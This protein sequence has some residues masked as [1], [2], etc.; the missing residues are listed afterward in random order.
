MIEV[1][2]GYPGANNALVLSAITT[3]GPLQSMG[4]TTI[5]R[6]ACACL[7]RFVA[8][9]LVIVPL[10]A[11]L[12][13]KLKSFPSSSATIHTSYAPSGLKRGHA[14]HTGYCGYG[15]RSDAF[16]THWLQLPI[17]YSLLMYSP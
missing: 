4:L 15:G 13:L 17:V 7:F 12:A 9:A 10:P 8:T 2:F 1:S 16:A 14:R 3:V 11:A 6:V 5:T